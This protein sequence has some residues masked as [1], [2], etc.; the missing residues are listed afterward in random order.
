MS[1]RQF[2]DM[3]YEFD[4]LWHSMCDLAMVKSNLFI[5]FFSFHINIFKKTLK[6]LPY[7]LNCYCTSLSTW[8]IVLDKNNFVKVSH[9]Y[10]TSGGYQVCLPPMPCGLID[11]KFGNMYHEFDSLWHAMCNLAMV[12]SNLLI[13]SFYLQ[14]FFLKNHLN[15][16][17]IY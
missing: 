12:K 8:F 6:W 2:G 1:D 3:Y 15:D 5:V 7:I 14:N 11:W 16:Y 13:V 17:L 4:S 10:L 9:H